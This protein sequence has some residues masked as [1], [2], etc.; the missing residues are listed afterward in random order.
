[1]IKR[2]HSIS[3]CDSVWQV[4]GQG[5]GSGSQPG[6]LRA[7]FNRNHLSAMKRQNNVLLKAGAFTLIELLVVIAIIAILAAMLL[8][9]L[10]KSKL[11]ATE[12]ACLSNERQIGLAVTMYAPDNS[13]KL[14]APFDTGWLSN[15]GGFWL[16][17]SSVPGSWSGSAAVALADVQG[18]L[19]TNNLLFQYASSAGVY[20]CPGD[21]RFNNP[22]G[23]G[24][25]YDSYSVTMNVGGA[26]PGEMYGMSF[27]TKLSQIKR[28]SEC[29]TFVE[30]AD[31]R[32]F[33]QGPFYG[34]VNVGDP[35]TFV[36]VD[37][38]ATYHGNIG[39]V[40]FADAHAEFHKWNDP[41]IIG[42]GNSANNANST[43]YDYSTN[44]RSPS[45]A[46]SDTA[47]LTQHW[48]CPANP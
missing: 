26:L 31:C 38:F 14:L 10:A 6:T 28:A 3:I 20:H 45:E 8:P 24:W 2:A 47:W 34:A 44:R 22:V 40:C 4:A 43:V 9:A 1:M 27:F 23:K 16:I 30:Q 7:G 35:S 11:K 46:G 13:D 39:T 32:G 15:A 5:W 41:A 25:A 48:L 18:H 17:D 19:R 37:L 12:A 33:N 21:V 42:A 29:M 36:Y